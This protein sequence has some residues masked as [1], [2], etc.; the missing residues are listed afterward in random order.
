MQMR[1]DISTF[2]RIGQLVQL[3]SPD[4]NVSGAGRRARTDII[5]RFFLPLAL[6]VYAVVNVATK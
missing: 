5:K 6:E 1:R 3:T 2:D 4:A